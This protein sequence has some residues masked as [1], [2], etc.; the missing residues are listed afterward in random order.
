MAMTSSP[1][2]VNSLARI[3]PVQPR[4]MMTTSFLGSLRAMA[5]PLRRPFRA[6]CETHWRQWIGLVVTIDPVEIIVAGA[7]EADHLPG[8]HVA[9][10]AIDRIGEK[11]HLDILDG[12]REERL[13]VERLA[14]GPLELDAAVVKTFEGLVLVG[15]GKLSERLAGK[16]GAAIF[17]E[18]GET[19]AVLLRR[20]FLGL[21]AEVFGA[22]H[23][24]RPIVMAF[25]V[26]VGAGHLAVKIERAAGV[27][28]AGGLGI[29]RDYAIG[30]RFDR[31]AFLAGK[32]KPWTQSRR[33][34]WMPCVGRP[35]KFAGYNACAG[36]DAGDH[37][38]CNT[39]QKLATMQH[40]NN[41]RTQRPN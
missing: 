28:A 27:L 33:I 10:A 15:V 23:E 7:G 31:G 5:L 12:L 26:A 40:I 1:S 11:P 18:R 35:G 32:I 14:I 9:I 41:A 25:L 17:V 39:S 4:P 36:G 16:T 8:H 30:K 34:G 2:S 38:P 24:R 3:Q 19:V 20:S 21:R 22:G 37:Q 6:A 13:A 29:R